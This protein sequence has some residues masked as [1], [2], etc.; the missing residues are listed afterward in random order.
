MAI[1][2]GLLLFSHSSY[3]PLAYTIIVAGI[4]VLGVFIAPVRTPVRYVVIGVGLVSFFIFFR[5]NFSVEMAGAF[6]LMSSIFKLFEL[7]KLRDLHSFVFVTL[8]T[9]AVSFLF[10]QD[11]L[12]TVLQ[13]LVVGLGFYCLL[14]VHGG[15]HWRLGVDWS[16]LLKV[17]VFALPFVVV[18]FLFF[19]RIDPLWSIPVK[20][21]YAKTGMGDEMSPGDIERL[22]QSSDRVFRVLFHGNQVPPPEH[23]YW[24]GVALDQFDGRSWSRSVRRVFAGKEKFDSVR[25]TTEP[26]S[27]TYEVMLEPHFQYWAFSLLGSA[28]ASTNLRSGDMG[29]LELES[30]AIQATRYLLSYRPDQ[31]IDDAKLPGQFISL[32]GVTG[33]NGVGRTGPSPRH[34]QDLQLPKGT[35]P[36]TREFVA[37]LKQSSASAEELVFKLF[38]QFKDQEFYYTLEPPL[39]GDDYV[40][41]FLFDARRGFCAHFAG[42]LAF[43]LRLADIPARVVIGYQGGEF[44]PDGG[45]FII[46]QFD[47]HAW[48]EAEIAGVGWVQ[49]DPT[50]LIAPDRIING[51]QSAMREEGSFLSNSPIASAARHFSTLSWVRLRLDKLN[52]QWQKWVV[53][54]SPEQQSSFVT[55]LY[56]QFGKNY[57][58]IIFVSLLFVVIF[59]AFWFLS[60]RDQK[61]QYSTAARR[62]NRWCWW[63]ARFGYVRQDNETPRAFL[64]RVEQGGQTRLISLVRK[65]TERLERHEYQR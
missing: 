26:G 50:A 60:L 43:M 41:D 12:H 1:L 7:R 64:A 24:R 5:A 9:S 57:L 2:A 32:P 23:R 52:Y 30:E 29:L 36:R 44:N 13:F 56:G 65:I 49:L 19:P 15:A 47:A 34:Y 45:Y 40:D 4:A 38:T 33:V 54:Y 31:A 35:N 39:L 42:S 46:H 27:G 22:S 25:F 3:L 21:S 8:Y 6:L 53:N 11:F 28:P 59:G 10:A 55:A 51:L 63:L 48:V 62:Y 14:K 37:G 16:A 58:S 20:T 17:A 18:C 61:V